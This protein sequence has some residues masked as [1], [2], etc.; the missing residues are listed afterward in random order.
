MNEITLTEPL[1]QV[2]PEKSKTLFF[3]ISGSSKIHC[4]HTHSNTCHR[5]N[6]YGFFFFKYT[7]S[8]TIEITEN[9]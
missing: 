6:F 5:L 1:R 3:A 2:G 7:E 8:I 4:T 9:F